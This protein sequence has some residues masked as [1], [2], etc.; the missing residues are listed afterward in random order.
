MGDYFLNYLAVHEL[1]TFLDFKKNL[2]VIIKDT[3]TRITA[4]GEAPL[5]YFIPHLT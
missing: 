2:D 3:S 1:D 5:D 4:H